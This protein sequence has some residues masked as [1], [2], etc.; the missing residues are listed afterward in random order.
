MFLTLCDAC[1]RDRVT[2]AV[3]ELIESGCLQ[4]LKT[5]W[6]FER[7]ECSGKDGPPKKVGRKRSVF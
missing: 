2:L 3:L 6:W 4:G 5:K 1:C 7:G